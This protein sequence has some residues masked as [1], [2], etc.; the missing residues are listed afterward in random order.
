MLAAFLKALLGAVVAGVQAFFDARARDAA[1][2]EAGR[3]EQAV[4]DEKAARAA[5]E[6]I[7]GIA[8]DQAENNA[9]DRGGAGGVLERLRKSGR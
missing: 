9:A 4:A 1:L 3:A 7:R 6:E 2:R 8:D 5:A